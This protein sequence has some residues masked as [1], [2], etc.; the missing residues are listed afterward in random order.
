MKFKVGD[1]VRAIS[2]AKPSTGTITNVLGE[3]FYKVRLDCETRPPHPSFCEDGSWYIFQYNSDM[4]KYEAQNTPTLVIYR[5]DTETIALLK[6]GKKTIKQAS[7]KCHPDDTYDFE[8]GARLAMDRLFGK[9]DK[10]A[11]A[12][13]RQGPKVVTLS[14]AEIARAAKRGEWIKVINAYTTDGCYCNGD[15]FMVDEIKSHGVYITTQKTHACCRVEGRTNQSFLCHN[16][17]VVL[18]PIRKGRT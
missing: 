7:A 8:T 11:D 17:Y 15:V 1:K 12:S 9:V 6:E 16:E 10:M 18:E 13:E 4:E 14:F 5:K 2:W 3:D